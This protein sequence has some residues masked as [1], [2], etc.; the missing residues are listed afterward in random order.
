M[1]EEK[2]RSLR[3]TLYRF[4]NGHCAKNLRR[5]YSDGKPNLLNHLHSLSVAKMATDFRT[6]NY[7][8]DNA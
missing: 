5:I 7:E 2:D 4:R 6:R 1:E 3:L 8:A